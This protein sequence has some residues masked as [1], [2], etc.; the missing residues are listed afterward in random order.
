MKKFIV[1]EGID[2]CGKGTVIKHIYDFL[3]DKKLDVGCVR[4]PG[5][6]KVSESI[7]NILLDN[8][9]TEI[10][11]ETELLLYVAARV[12]LLVEEIEPILSQNKI[13]LCDRYDLST[14][15]YQY[16][17]GNWEDGSL[18][19]MTNAIA[20]GNRSK[21]DHY[22]ILDVPVHIAQKRVGIEKDRQENK[23]TDLFEK[24]RQ[25]YLMYAEKWN[26]T[27]VID[28]SAPIEDVLI[29]VE[30]VVLKILED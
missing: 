14:L 15:T 1:F 21:P 8:A 11:R 23:G 24:V 12:Q 17:F 22:I 20:L 7:R 29:K 27:T 28:S 19:E 16:V 26:N 5:T 9:N 6:T 2:G 18:I 10:T 3:L 30:E 4:D 25:R 13:V